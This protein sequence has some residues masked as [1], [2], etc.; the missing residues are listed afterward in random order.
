MK[1]LTVLFLLG[2][3]LFCFGCS[4]TITAPTGSDTFIEGE[5][6]TF[7]GTAKS[8]L[9][10]PITDDSQFIWISNIDGEIGIGASIS[11]AL[12]D[13]EHT[14]TL[15]F[16]DFNDWA[17]LDSISITVGSSTLNG[18]LVAYYPFN[19]NAN[20]ESGNGNNGTVNG[21][22][23]SEN[24]FEDLNSAYSF[25]GIDD[26]ISLG[27]QLQL[28]K[29]TISLWINT[30]A[31]KYGASNSMG[32][33][34]FREYGYGISMNGSFAGYGGTFTDIGKIYFALHS[35]NSEENVLFEHITNSN[36]YND[37]NWHYLTMSYNGAT[38]RVFIDAELIYENLSEPSEV[39]YN[40]LDLAIGRDGDHSSD[41]FIGKIDDIRIYNRALTEAEIQELYNLTE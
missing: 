12:A 23:L 36:D 10:Q 33:I 37:G 17:T 24:R 25:D 1:K 39:K 7:T 30:S 21:A 11:V 8:V 32:I 6:I 13:G 14:I 38:S 34:R 19:G 4:T 35:Q 3:S 41:Y 27:D 26:Y 16:P 20:D 29:I 5:E 22:T 28:K 18:G 40:P 9:G 2:F 15:Q 31:T